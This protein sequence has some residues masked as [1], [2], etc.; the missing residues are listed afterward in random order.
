MPVVTLNST[1]CRDDLLFELEVD[2]IRSH[3]SF[4]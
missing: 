1:I 2:A 4:A 3:G